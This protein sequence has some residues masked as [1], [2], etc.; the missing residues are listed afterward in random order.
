M[1]RLRIAAWG[2][3]IG[4]FL[5]SHLERLGQLVRWT[6]GTTPA[7]HEDRMSFWDEEIR[8]KEFERGYSECREA[9]RRELAIYLPR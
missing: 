4:D 3:P 8:A 2:T 6:G 7:E 9:A 1:R 5:A